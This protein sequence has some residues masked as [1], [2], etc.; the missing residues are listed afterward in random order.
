MNMKKKIAYINPQYFID[1]DL[2]V[3]KYLKEKFEVL[4]IPIINKNNP[5]YRVDELKEYAEK[6]NIQIVVFESALRMRSVKNIGF[7]K[8]ILR[9]IRDNNCSLIF[10]GLSNVYWT[11]LSKYLVNV[12]IVRGIHDYKLHSNFNASF[13][14]KIT[15]HLNILLN[16][17]FLFYSK[18]QQELFKADYPG[19]TSEMV[20]MS[21]K[22][23]GDS[24]IHKS[25]IQQE[26]KL[27]FFGR[28]DSYKGLND[29][30]LNI[31]S[32][33]EHG[34]RNLKLS[35]CGKGAFWNECK[36]LIKNKQLYNLQ[37]RFIDNEEV[38]NLF[39]SHHFLVLPYHDATQSGPVM[40]AANYGLPIIAPNF[41]CFKSIYNQDAA[42]L[43]EDG[44]LAKALLKVS[45]LTQTEYMHLEEGAENIKMAYSGEKI[46]ER[47]ID[48]FYKIIDKK[49]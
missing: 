18:L 44:E 2:T 29:L 26:V 42:I 38:P 1:T 6:N 23:F 5:S 41:G 46:A 43:Y 48:Y 24:D 36:G 7:Y 47:Y 12:P 28:I 17:Y 22:D 33:Y 13:F 10:T 8:Q 37:V 39:E 31:E 20:G 34:I 49:I 15:N 21:V 35:V 30:I 19:K 25:L 9:M 3:L 11:V 14:L 16:K 4:W 27:L 32:L 40:I 45:K